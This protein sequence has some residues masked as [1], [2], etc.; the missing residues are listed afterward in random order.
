AAT[1]KTLLFFSFRFQFRLRR[2]REKT[3][4]SY[5]ARKK[6]VG[7]VLRRILRKRED[8]RIFGTLLCNKMLLFFLISIFTVWP[9]NCIIIGGDDIISRVRNRETNANRVCW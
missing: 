2:A 3:Q 5:S 9:L 1:A 6:P 7:R 4:K 8:F